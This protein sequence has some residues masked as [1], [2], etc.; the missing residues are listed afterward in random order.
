[1]INFG[2]KIRE[3]RLARRMT[4]AELE[5]RCGL[6]REYLSRLETGG[7]PNATIRTLCKIADGLRVPVTSLLVQVP[8]VFATEN[9]IFRA[10]K[11]GEDAANARH[12]QDLLGLVEQIRQVNM[13]WGKVGK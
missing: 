5:K 7:L 2:K 1:M 12:V 9:A 13:P 8:T 11:R 3:I 10:E 6:K 4:Q